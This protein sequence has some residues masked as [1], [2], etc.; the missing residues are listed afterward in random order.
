LL[1]G[2]G[3]RRRLAGAPA[4]RIGASRYPPKPDTRC[5][6]R[7]ATVRTGD[8]GP[9]RWA[10]TFWYVQAT[11]E[12]LV[13]VLAARTGA[14][15]GSHAGAV[16]DEFAAGLTVQYAA[17]GRPDEPLTRFDL[18][19]LGIAPRALRRAAYE[20]LAVLAEGAHLH[21]SPP[22]FMV[23]FHGI[24][25]SLLLADGFW[26]AVIPDLM[27]DL[28]G[29]L[30]VAVPARDVLLITGSRSPAGLAKAMRCVDRVFY[31]GGPGLLTES[32]LVRR[33]SGWEVF[34]PTPASE[35]EEDVGDWIPEDRKDNARE[36]IP[37]HLGE[38][39]S[40]PAT[41]D[42]PSTEEWTIHWSRP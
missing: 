15:T 3:Y 17:A 36:W 29:E 30:V 18:Q 35:A 27:F 39:V 40:A 9:A 31:A 23:S 24:E 28:P 14:H 25:S 13:P 16:E 33:A 1:A 32:L 6:K 8:A 41:A 37:E 11:R 7:T 10:S 22:A 2:K 26:Q 42:L 21:G 34:D 19:T 20:R 12:S 5:E 38:R 4:Y